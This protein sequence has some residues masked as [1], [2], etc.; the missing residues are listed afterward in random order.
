MS[1]DPQW[2]EIGPMAY[3]FLLQIAGSFHSVEVQTFYFKIS[4]LQ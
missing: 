4:W 3:L 1:P 2:A